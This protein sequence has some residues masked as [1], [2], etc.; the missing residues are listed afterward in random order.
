MFKI[1]ILG[2]DDLDLLSCTLLGLAG[3]NDSWLKLDDEL[4]KIGT[5]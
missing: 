5:E 2:M 3:R 4:D 1:F